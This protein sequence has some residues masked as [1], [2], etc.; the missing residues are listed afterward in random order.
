[1]NS[2]DS[3]LEH[4]LD[5]KADSKVK[6]AMNYSLLGKAKRIRPRL[7]FSVLNAYGLSSEK[8]Y[9]C[10]AGIELIHTY[11]LIHDD[12]PCMDNDDLR[13]GRLTCHKAFDEAT[14]LLAGDACLTHAFECAANATNQASVNVEIV[15]EFVHF[16]GMEGMILGQQYDLE[17]ENK[18]I[19]LNQCIQ[20][21]ELK[22]GALI[23]CSLVC[24]ALIADRKA[25]ISLWRNIGY[26]L[27]LAF[28]IQDD[29]LDVIGNVEELGKSCSDEENGKVTFVSL[30]GF[31]E[32]ERRY[33]NLY[34]DIRN[35]L[36]SMM[37]HGEKFEEIL[38]LLENR[39]H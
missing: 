35:D 27:G 1:M 2:F 39:S 24:G 14:A 26:K 34:A 6:E 37:I 38:S 17:N 8:G 12:L 29:C 21:D 31:E 11:S 4:L 30:L 23:A 28:Q 36:H 7:L 10:A 5:D 22:T 32:A 15:K 33:K 13:R 20:V 9:A 3:Y 19:D 18:P 25:D 16:A